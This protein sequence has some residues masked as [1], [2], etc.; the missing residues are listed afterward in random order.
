MRPF[1]TNGTFRPGTESHE[2]IRIAVR[3]GAATILASGLALT[4]QVISTVILA[5]LLVPADFGVLSMATTFS[6]FFLSFG[7]NGFTEAVIQFEEI[8][9]YTASNLFWLNSVAGLVLAIAFVAG[10]ALLARFYQ[11]PLVANVSTGLSAGIF[12]AGA[13]VIH[14][15]LLKRAMRF[16]ATSINDVVGR[17]VNTAVAVLLALRGWG[18]WALVV[19]IVAQQVSVTMGA[20]WL[21]RWVPS[22]PRRTGKTGAMLRFAAKVYGQFTLRYATQNTD[23]LL[24]GWQFH[25]VGLGFYK[26]AYDLFA[27]SAAQLMAPLFNVALATLSQLIPEPERF[28]RYLTNSLGI[29]AFIG[30]AVGADL[31]L[32]GKDVVRLVLGQQWEESGRIFELFGP[33]IGAMLLYGIVAWIHLSIGK[34]GRLLRWSLVELAL[35]VS[36]F[37]WALRWGSAGIAAAWSISYWILLIPAFWYAGRPIGFGV[38]ALIAA[39]WRFVAAALAA[40]LTTAAIMRGTPF[41]GTPTGANAAFGAIIV[42]SALFVT[43]YLGTVILLHRGLAPLHQLGTLLGEL[44]PTRGATKPT[45]KPVGDTNEPARNSLTERSGVPV[46]PSAASEPCPQCAVAVSPVGLAGPVAVPDDA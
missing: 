18:Y 28:R 43:L 6:L 16:A 30:M 46:A 45:A 4:V 39:V 41:W 33:G 27:L 20:W 21:C 2:L 13:S 3:G 38:S 24:V 29:I 12:I 40:G 32:V 19:G 42:V 37:L 44:A 14:L 9:H 8:N 15:A 17:A 5:R 23:N 7:L 25:A 1:D 26:R 11:N 34:P 10:G 35:T 36:L 31:T 22:L